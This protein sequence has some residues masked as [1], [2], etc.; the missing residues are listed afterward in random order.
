MGCHR[1]LRIKVLIEFKR[2]KSDMKSVSLV[3]SSERVCAQ[4]CI[5]ALDH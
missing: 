5:D 2:R 1:L 3:A 4:R